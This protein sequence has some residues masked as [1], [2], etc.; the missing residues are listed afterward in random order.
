MVQILFDH[1]QT[2]G[3]TSFDHSHKYSASGHVCPHTSEGGIAHFHGGCGE[4]QFTLQCTLDECPTSPQYH[5][6]S[7][8]T[9]T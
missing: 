4:C 8:W 6:R 5:L 7:H 9:T 2:M 1:S 3:Q